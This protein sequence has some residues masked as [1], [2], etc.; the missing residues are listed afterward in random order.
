[1]SNRELFSAKYQV[2]F[3][4]T[5]SAKAFYYHWVGKMPGLMTIDDDVVTLVRSVNSYSEFVRVQRT[6]TNP[7]KNW[8][9]VGF[10]SNMIE[11]FNYYMR[12]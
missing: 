6:F 2:H 7:I 8:H 11:A 5:D 4:D 10:G 3:T 1:M 12:G 9:F